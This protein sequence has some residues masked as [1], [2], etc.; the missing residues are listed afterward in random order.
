MSSTSS[1]S[2]SGSIFAVP[3]A[4]AQ[5]SAAAAS[6][7]RAKSLFAVPE[8]ATGQAVERKIKSLREEVNREFL[9]LAGIALK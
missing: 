4:P 5:L 3:T 7:G 1:S 8:S 2:S 6:A 9:I